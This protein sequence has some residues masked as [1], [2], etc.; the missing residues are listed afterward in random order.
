MLGQGLVIFLK[1]LVFRCYVLQLGVQFIGPSNN[2]IKVKV[3]LAENPHLIVAQSYVIVEFSIEAAQLRGILEYA[4]S[5]LMLF[6][7]E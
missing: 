5:L 7:L 3:C 2:G 6:H 4:Y 1:Y